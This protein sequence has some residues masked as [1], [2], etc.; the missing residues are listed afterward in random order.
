[1]LHQQ[2]LMIG[3]IS[4]SFPSYGY[5]PRDQSGQSQTGVA[6]AKKPNSKAFA[7]ETDKA[8]RKPT[9]PNELTPEEKEQVAKLKA[10]DAEVRAHEMAHMAA[11]GSLAMGGP[12]YVYQT[13][14]DGRN[15]AVGGDVKIDTS[16]GRTPEETIRK[17]EQIRAAALAPAEPSVQDLRVANSASSMALE[18]QRKLSEK[19]Q[20][21]SQEPGQP[22]GEITSIRQLVAFT[23]DLKNEEADG[24]AYNQ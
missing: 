20:E 1:M 22:N 13:G 7:A 5:G 2:P 16:P 4:S 10:R 8:K 23:E 18:A 12:N 3:S 11:A 21:E 9:Q 15:Y 6:E 19:Q 17:A 24:H 14:P